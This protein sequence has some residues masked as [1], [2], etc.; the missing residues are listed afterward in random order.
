MFNWWK[1]RLLPQTGANRIE[2]LA[3]RLA[4]EGKAAN[5]EG[6]LD[7]LDVAE[8]S[9]LEIESWYHLRGI[10][11]FRR[12]DRQLAK[13]RFAEAHSKFPVSYETN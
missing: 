2:A 3:D 4:R 5:I 10:A 1:K 11:A 9:S 13:A 6:E 12:G 7:A 8:L